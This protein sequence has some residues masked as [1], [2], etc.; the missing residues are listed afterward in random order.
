MFHVNFVSPSLET[1]TLTTTLFHK[2]QREIPVEEQEE[3]KM[4]V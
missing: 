2:P 1:I 4:Q 3:K